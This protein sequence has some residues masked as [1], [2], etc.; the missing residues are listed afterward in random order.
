MPLRID[1]AARYFP[2][3]EDVHARTAADNPAA[4]TRIVDRIKKAVE[5]LLDFPA[6]GRPGRVDGTRELVVPGAP[7]IVPYRL[8]GDG[9]QILALIHNAQRWPDR[10]P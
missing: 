4:A 8:V 3:L 5:R 10:F 9:V 6:L 2:Q 1:Y 7:Y